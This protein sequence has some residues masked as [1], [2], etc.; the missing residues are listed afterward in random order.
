M[1]SS[2]R[3]YT[4]SATLVAL[5]F[6]A[7][8]TTRQTRSV[9][10]SGFL[11]DYSMLRPGTGEEAQLI[12]I[13]PGADFASYDKVMLD[14]VSIVFTRGSASSQKVSDAEIKRLADRLY[15]AVQVRLDDDYQ[16]VEKP[17][18]GV[19]RIRA[20][21]TEVRGS[22]V[23]VDVITTAI[24]QIKMIATV[25]QLATDAHLFVGSAGIEVE[26]L[27]SATGERL[28]AVVDE[29]AG[30]KVLRGS[31]STWNDVKEA[32]DYWAERLGVRLAELRAA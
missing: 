32:F 7:C 14:P 15:Y 24:P 6:A 30:T 8:A 3:R 2:V 26:I 1:S 5:S 19:L 22:N 4:I 23:A 17:G 31:T 11:G 13:N 28:A 29:R 16:I 10:T 9:E 21:L 20:A 12:Y 18:P 27:D 25:G